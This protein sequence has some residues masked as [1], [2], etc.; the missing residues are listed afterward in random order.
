MKISDE[1]NRSLKI[2]WWAAM[3]AAILWTLVYRLGAQASFAADF[4]Y[5]NF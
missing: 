4:V 1:A 5:V 2:V 3:V